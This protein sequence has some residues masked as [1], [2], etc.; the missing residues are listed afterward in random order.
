MHDP[1]V[2]TIAVIA[3]VGV[4]LALIDTHMMRKK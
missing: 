2:I 3:V 4:V 1:I